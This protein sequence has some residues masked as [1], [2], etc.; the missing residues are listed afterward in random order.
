LAVSTIIGGAG[1]YRLTHRLGRPSVDDPRLG[2]EASLLSAAIRDVVD[3]QWTEYIW[4]FRLVRVRVEDLGPL[5]VGIDAHGNSVYQDVKDR[6]HARLA[7]I[8]AT[9]TEQREADTQDVAGGDA[10]GA[11]GNR[12]K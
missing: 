9:L 8:R 2:D 12:V 3:V 7:D 1:P 5:T 11:L 4:Q 6:A 10:S